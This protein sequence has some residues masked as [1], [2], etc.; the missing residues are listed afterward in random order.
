MM[1][2]DFLRFGRAALAAFFLLLLAVAPV[3][4]GPPVAAPPLGERWFGIMVDNEQVGFSRL[5]ISR[6][7]EGGYRIDGDGSVRMQIMGFTREATFREQYVVTPALTLKSLEVEQSLGGKHSQLSGKMVGGGLQVRREADGKVTERL[8]KSR[9]EVFP[10]SVLNLLPLMRG[11]SGGKQ[12]RVQFFDPEEVRIKEVKISVVGV[13]RTPDGQPAI[14]MR[15]DLYPFVSNDIWVDD[16]GN[17]L[18]ESVR[19]GLVVTRTEPPE[20]LAPLVSGLALSQKDLIYDFSMVRATPALSR[21]M[22]ELK[23]LAALI[24]GYGDTLP[25]LTDSAQSVERHNGQLTIR[26]GS[27]RREELA[28]APPAPRYLRPSERIESAAPQIVSRA[29]ELAGSASTV[30]EKVARLTDW[31]ARWLE[32]GIDDSG[33]ALAALSGKRG[34][35]QSHARLYTALARAA[36]IPTRFV[37]GLVTQDG[38]GFL[39]HSWA[40]SW[41]DDRWL[42]VDPTFNQIPA[43]P[44]HLAF[45]EGDSPAD[46]APLVSL[47]GRIRLQILEQAP[48]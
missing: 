7:P 22:A 2:T 27:L 4:A 35:C 47:I 5:R 39:Y 37:S 36:G 11:G 21:P 31:T 1:F 18:L 8:L 16:Q 15:N 10:A 20:T 9:G 44:S 41:V 32:D 28:A 33:S 3:C 25:L 26:T 42:A 45:F 24:Q 40:E 30:S 13:E 23:G 43:D 46:L 34:N 29:A 14:R 48:Q 17:T 12:Y 6:L 19:D 38:K